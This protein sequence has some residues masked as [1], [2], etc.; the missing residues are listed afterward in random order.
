MSLDLII[1]VN[2]SDVTLLEGKGNY[3]NIKRIFDREAISTET[4]ML[5]SHVTILWQTEPE[6]PL[7]MSGFF[8][9]N[10]HAFSTGDIVIMNCMVPRGVSRD[11]EVFS[12]WS[13]L[14]HWNRPKIH[15]DLVN[16]QLI[17][18]K[19]YW[20]TY[21]IDSDTLER[22]FGERESTQFVEDSDNE[23]MSS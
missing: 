10:I 4:W 20:D 16:G 3:N 21:L 6:S 19:H 14:N 17:N 5:E 12:A 13:Q 22:K 1:D 9:A 8:E 11:I 18:W 15:G 7:P 23:Y 2:F